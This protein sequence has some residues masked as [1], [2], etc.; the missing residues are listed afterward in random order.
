[1]RYFQE[2][3]MGLKLNGTYPLLLYVDDMNAFEHNIHSTKQ[4]EET[5]WR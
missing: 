3:Q 2:Y 5:H 4:K 1:M